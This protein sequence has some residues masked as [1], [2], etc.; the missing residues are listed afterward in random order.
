M[1]EFMFWLVF[2]VALLRWMSFGFVIS[3]HG[4]EKPTSKYNAYAYFFTNLI[5]IFIAY[6]IYYK[7]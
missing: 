4:E 3:K 5:W 7:L 2:T 6:T 1:G